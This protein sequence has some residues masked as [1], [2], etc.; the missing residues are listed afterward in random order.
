MILEVLDPLYVTKDNISE[1]VNGNK[2]EVTFIL[3]K[4][5]RPVWSV[6]VC[7][8]LYLSSVH[9]C[10]FNLHL[11]VDLNYYLQPRGRGWLML[12]GSNCL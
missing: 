5:C 9:Q 3:G 12:E 1:P 11:V 2:Y 8:G 7:Y 4:K 6:L 10:K